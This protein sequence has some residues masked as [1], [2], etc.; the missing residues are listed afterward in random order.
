M[1]SRVANSLYDVGRMTERADHVARV[2]EVFA[3]LALDRPG[4]GTDAFWN[5]TL[6]LLGWPPMGL[7]DRETA[8]QLAVG[9]GGGPSLKAAI[10]AARQSALSVRP[11]LS[12]EVFECLN[13][14]HWRPI[15]A[16]ARTDLSSF[17]ISVQRGIQL[18]I[19]LTED[20]MS[21]DE[22]W[23]FVRLGRFLQRAANVTHFVLERLVALAGS[24]AGPV[25]WAAVLRS[26]SSFEAYRWRY[27][28]TVTPQRVTSFLLLDPLLPRS[29]AHCLAQALDSI[30]RIDGG[31]STSEPHRALGRLVS[32]VQYASE[33]EVVSN[34]VGFGRQFDQ[35]MSR[36]EASLGNAFF[37][38]SRVPVPSNTAL[39]PALPSWAQHEQQQQ[40]QSL[41]RP[42]PGPARPPRCGSR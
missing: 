34:P 12:V 26:C 32:L 42:T 31:S 37:R 35:L 11:S 8:I 15:E 6:E 13:Q 38:P 27:S 24:S 22:A 20:T 7:L 29:T 1:L 3:G 5:E 41:A 19:G 21:H 14:L 2:L 36:V 30:R 4:K 18:F 16:E 9:G 28:A 23:D 39:P 17:L 40:Q 33:E 25:E 10:A